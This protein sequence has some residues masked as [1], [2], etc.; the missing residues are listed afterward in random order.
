MKPLPT[1]PVPPGIQDYVSGT[2]KVP[3]RML[4][5]IRR[6]YPADTTG[7]SIVAFAR[8]LYPEAEMIGA[9]KDGVGRW[10][11][12]ARFPTGVGPETDQVIES[13]GV[14]K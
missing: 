13:E 7:D 6:K 11:V 9:R 2:V 4:K 8:G 3:S 10:W 5:S 12:T 1:G 14:L